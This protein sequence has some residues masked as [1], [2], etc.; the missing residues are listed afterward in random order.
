MQPA[1]RFS[2]RGRPDRQLSK[3]LSA[4]AAG[5]LTQ[6]QDAGILHPAEND[7]PENVGPSVRDHPRP[8]AF[9]PYGKYS[10]QDTEPHNSQNWPDAFV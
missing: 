1:S 9:S 3:R 7:Y 6:D 2:T 4:P 5:N 10:E 8:K